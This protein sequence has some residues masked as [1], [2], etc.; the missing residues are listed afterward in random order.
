LIKISVGNRSKTPAGQVSQQDEP[1]SIEEPKEDFT[2]LKPKTAKP[3][4]KTPA[5]R[6]GS[7]TS[8]II[9]IKFSEICR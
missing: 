4:K 2:G 1:E 9:Q 6:I 3:G 7:P 8:G 5:G